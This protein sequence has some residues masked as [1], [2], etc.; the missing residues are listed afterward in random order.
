MCLPFAVCK[1]LNLP[2]DAEEVLTPYLLEVGVGEAF[3]LE[4]TGEVEHLGGVG[5]ADD[6]AIAIEV[7]ADAHM[8]DASHIHH[9]DDVAHGIAYGGRAFGLGTEE[10]AV[11][12]H[13]C[14][15]A[16]VAQGTELVV[17]EVA[18]VVAEGTAAAVAAHDGGAAA[19]QGI[20]EALLSR[21]REIDHHAHAVHL[22]HHLAT[23]GGEATVREA[24]LIAAGTG[25]GTDGVVAVVAKGHIHHAPTAEMADEAEV[26]ADG[27]AV[28]DAQHDGLASLLLEEVEV[29]GGTG[30]GHMR[31][32]AGSD[33][34]DAVEQ[35]LRPGQGGRVIVVAGEILL[36]VGHHDGGVEAAVG[37][38]GQVDEDALVA[39]VEI[40][41][42][43]E[44]HG[45][46]A[47]GVEGEMGVVELPGMGIATGF[48]D[49][50]AEDG[51]HA[52]VAPEDETLRMPLHAEHGLV[53]RALH[54]LDDAVGRCGS[55]T[56]ARCR[57]THRLMVE[58]VDSLPP[59][60]SQGG[61][62]G[63]Q[64]SQQAIGGK[65]DG[66]MGDIAGLVALVVTLRSP[67]LHIDI[68][69][70]LATQGSRHDLYAT[71]DA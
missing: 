30:D 68:L 15:A 65:M 47:M 9:V 71:A 55:H 44:E 59:S 62:A 35:A 34:L 41:M 70:E 20:V 49:E 27:I 6:A 42:L 63:Q 46:V 18:G 13:L 2:H 1:V 8:V 3:G 4:V 33:G 12:A 24:V 57:L 26:V 10:A 11:E 67:T 36:D 51:H 40:D 61:G 64:G 14:H 29:V 58:A 56:E 17:G 38:I 52:L 23:K 69:P 53:L 39:G 54:S 7:G 37:H 22:S 31:R 25:A 50:P 19:L 16:T 60:P 43:V 5:A 66:V 48:A 21:M 45:R 32:V 28:L